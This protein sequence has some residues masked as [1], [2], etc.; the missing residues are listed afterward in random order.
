MQ[1][2]A[3]LLAQYRDRFTKTLEA[4]PM[5]K[6][7]VQQQPDLLVEL[8]KVW[9]A[10][11]QAATICCN[12][13]QLLQDLLSC[14]D[15]D[16]VYASWSSHLRG[17]LERFFT[18]DADISHVALVE[19]LQRQLRFFRQREWLRIVWRDVTGRASLN[20]TCSD[21]SALADAC[22]QIGRA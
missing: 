10:S 16:N 15:L 5:L 3:H 6:T 13:G 20:E 9:V 11:D 21:L 17:F 12:Q 2:V 22:I 8:D 1:E 14:K 7:A 4:H 18:G 19:R